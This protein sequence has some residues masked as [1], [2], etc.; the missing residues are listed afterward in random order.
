M[1]CSFGISNLQLSSVQ[2]NHSIVSNSLWPYGLQHDRPP[3][4]SVLPK[5]IPKFSSVSHLFPY[6]TPGC[7]LKEILVKTPTSSLF[8][9]TERPFL[10]LRARNFY[11]WTRKMKNK[12]NTEHRK[13]TLLP[14]WSVLL[15]RYDF[16]FTWKRFLLI[17]F[18]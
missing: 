10:V 3:C 11:F 9:L 4:P 2:F 14:R 15:N 6:V 12:R 8:F 18:F 16:I 17:E 1:K 7:A 5:F 13:F